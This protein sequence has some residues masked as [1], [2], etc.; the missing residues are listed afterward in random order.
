MAAEIVVDLHGLVGRHHEIVALDAADDAEPLETHPDRT[1]M[2][3]ARACDPQRRTRHRGE[4]DQ[5]ADLDMVGLNRVGRAA[6]RR[7]PVHD[8]RVGADALDL[9][10]ERDQEMREILHVRFGGGIAQIG[11][12]VGGDRR[13]QRV[14]GGGD[15]RLVEEDVGALELRGTKLQPVRGGDGGAQLLEGQKMRV[16]TPP[17]DH[18]A[19]GRRQRHLT[20]AG[21]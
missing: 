1:Q 21:Q 2:L 10:A 11:G 7:R 12:T 13:D 6:E 17:A 8:N 14:F 9:G 5:R 15:T 20:A 18:V 4:P 16:Q 19:A 3:D